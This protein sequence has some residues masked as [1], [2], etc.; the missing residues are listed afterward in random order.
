MFVTCPTAKEL[1]NTI[2]KYIKNRI[3]LTVS[4][5]VFNIIFGH[6]LTDHK[7]ILINTMLLVTKKCIF[8]ATIKE[9]NLNIEMVLCHLRDVYIEQQMLNCINGT[10]LAFNKIGNR[11]EQILN[12]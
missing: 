10:E 4:F 8:D 9:R 5:F 11:W 2:E 3:G 1:W 7:Q 6:T 12:G